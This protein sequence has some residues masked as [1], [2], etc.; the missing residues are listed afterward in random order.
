MF[1]FLGIFHEDEYMFKINH[2]SVDDY[3]LFRD[4]KA[5]VERWFADN[6]PG[7]IYHFDVAGSNSVITVKG[8]DPAM[9]FKLSFV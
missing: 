5:N 8:K 3:Y 1:E 4:W 9:F 2:R 6:L 7:A